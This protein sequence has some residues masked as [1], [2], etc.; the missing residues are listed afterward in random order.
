MPDMMMSMLPRRRDG[1]RS[2][3][4]IGTS[5]TGRRSW[6]ASAWAK[7]G[8][9]PVSFPFWTKDTGGASGDV[10]TRII[11]LVPGAGR[12][13]GDAGPQAATS[14]TASARSPR[15]T[16]GR[17]ISP[18]PHT[19]ARSLERELHSFGLRLQF[20]TLAGRVQCDANAVA[21]L[22]GGDPFA[23]ADGSRGL[24]RGI[25]PLEVAQAMQV[26]HVSD[27]V[28][29]GDADGVHRQPIDLERVVPSS[30]SQRA[31]APLKSDT[32]GDRLALDSQGGRRRFVARSPPCV[33]PT[34]QQPNDDRR[35]DADPSDHAHDS[36][37]SRWLGSGHG[38]G[39][40]SRMR[41][42]NPGPSPPACAFGTIRHCALSSSNGTR[43]STSPRS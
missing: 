26:V 7:S 14:M 21:V 22:H 37:S 40:P 24:D 34:D 27:R 39:T 15:T 11:A 29:G 30:I 9:I 35:H 3:Q 17:V 5:C 42:E 1:T 38:R 31:V 28:S 36:F 32:D 23:P 16:T 2:V 41:A 6:S 13:G 8:S 43:V 12:A 18:P 10:P 19:A 4:R 20:H 33:R 25:R